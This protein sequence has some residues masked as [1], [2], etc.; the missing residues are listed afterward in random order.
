VDRGGNEQ[1]NAP[2][3]PRLL[4]LEH[5]LACQGVDKTMRPASKT[6]EGGSV[7]GG[8]VTLWGWGNSGPQHQLICH[9][10][11][12]FSGMFCTAQGESRLD[13][14]CTR[15]TG[16]FD[17]TKTGAKICSSCLGRK[18]FYFSAREL[19]GK[20]CKMEYV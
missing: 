9:R 16:C 11:S 1:C 12:V 6:R 5:L 14:S 2:A 8:G 7:G 3:L 20:C 17:K 19:V 15:V 10:Y 18:E 13:S 4:G